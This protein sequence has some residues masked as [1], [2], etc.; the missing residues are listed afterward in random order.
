[1]AVRHFL[2]FLIVLIG[3]HCAIRAITS[4]MHNIT[5]VKGESVNH[6]AETIVRTTTAPI[7]TH[8]FFAIFAIV[9]FMAIIVLTIIVKKINAPITEHV[10]SVMP[11]ITLSRGS[12]IAAVMPLVHHVKK[13]LR[14]THTSVLCSRS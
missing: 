13:W 7:V 4:K 6:V 3:V 1:M 5:H 8:L 11:N 2:L 14:S 10:S 12:D 9:A